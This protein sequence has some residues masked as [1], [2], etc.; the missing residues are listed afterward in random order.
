MPG[1][2]LVVVKV[3]LEQGSSQGSNSSKNTVTIC[4]TDEVGEICMKSSAVG[5]S[6]WGLPGLTNSIFKIS[7]NDNP[8]NSTSSLTQE[9]APSDSSQDTT[10]A[11][12]IGGDYVRTGLLGFLGPGGLVFVCGSKDGLMTITGR[13]HNTDDIIATVL[14]VEPMKFIYR[15]R[16][17]VFS[18]KVLRDERVCVVAEQ[19]PDCSEEDSFQWMSRVLQAVDSIHQVGLYCLALVPHNHLPKT[20]LGGIHLSETRRR[21]IDGCLHPANVLMCPHTCVTNLP[22]PREVH[23]D[24]G[25]L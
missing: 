16:I 15:G 2:S 25:K 14:A 8:R 20:P 18:I 9:N 12:G 4:K 1:A 11:A 21:F 6:Y 24:V 17:A 5:S 7:P 19:R 10:V 22:K 3:E 13:K 23:P